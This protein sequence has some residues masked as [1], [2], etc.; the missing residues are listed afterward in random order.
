MKGVIESFVPIV[1]EQEC[2]A[3]R[4]EVMMTS[5]LDVHSQFCSSSMMVPCDSLWV[6]V[7]FEHEGALMC[8]KYHARG[9]CSCT[10]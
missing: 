4:Y 10:R 2:W 8:P 6:G 9:C 1:T 7:K 5:T 3:A